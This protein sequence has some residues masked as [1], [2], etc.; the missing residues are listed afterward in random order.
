[1]THSINVIFLP[2]HLSQ[3]TLDRDFS[4][5][6]VTELEARV[7][8]LEKELATAKD[9]AA[10]ALARAE[11][12]TTKEQ[13]ALQQEEELTPRVQAVVNSLTGKQSLPLHLPC[14]S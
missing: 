6:R 11:E 5:T 2:E 10:A 7:I 8:A 12:A 1:M 14:F 3:V 13:A 9:Q 4:N